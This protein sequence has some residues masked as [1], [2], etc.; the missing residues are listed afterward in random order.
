MMK[1]NSTFEYDVRLMMEMHSNKM[2]LLADNVHYMTV[3]SRGI[4]AFRARADS[5]KGDDFGPVQSRLN[6]LRDPDPEN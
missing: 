2:S 4:V 1:T 6:T 5:A 3:T